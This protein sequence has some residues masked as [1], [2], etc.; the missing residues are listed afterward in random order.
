MPYPSEHS[1][2]LRD[3]DDFDFE[4]ASGN[5]KANTAIRKMAGR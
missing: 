5:E 2:R 3:P 1:A 4:K